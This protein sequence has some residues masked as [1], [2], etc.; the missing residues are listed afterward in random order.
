METTTFYTIR[1][2]GH[3]IDQFDSVAEAKQERRNLVADILSGHR[4]GFLDPDDISGVGDF[5]IVAETWGDYDH[6][7]APISEM[8]VA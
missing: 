3:T 4:P 8:V 1:Y 5:S 6:D 7:P 2:L